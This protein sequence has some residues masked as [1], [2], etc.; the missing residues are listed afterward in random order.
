MAL[1]TIRDLSRK[2]AQ[3]AARNKT[4]PYV[5]FDEAEIE[6][7]QFVIPNLGDYRPKG[8][9]IIEELFCDKSGWGEP[10][11]PALTVRQLCDKMLEYQRAGKVYGYGMI[12]EGLFQCHVGVFEKLPKPPRKSRAKPKT[13]PKTKPKKK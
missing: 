6:E 9:K 2:A 5:P 10:G 13:K 1:E 7:R 12:E 4:V 3:Q 8:W 11:E